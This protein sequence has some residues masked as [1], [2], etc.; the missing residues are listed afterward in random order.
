MAGVH[1]L[2]TTSLKKQPKLVK[3]GGRGQKWEGD[4]GGGYKGKNYKLGTVS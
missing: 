4:R 3:P 2:E 1:F